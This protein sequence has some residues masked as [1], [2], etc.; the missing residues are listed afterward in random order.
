MK[1]TLTGH[2]YIRV[3]FSPVNDGI[4]TIRRIENRCDIPSDRDGLVTLWAHRESWAIIPTEN[5]SEGP[6]INTISSSLRETLH[7]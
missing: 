6:W 1:R 5:G 2:D 4:T 7:P 3:R